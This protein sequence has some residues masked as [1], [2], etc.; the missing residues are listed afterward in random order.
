[1]VG[2]GNHGRARGDGGVARRRLR[3]H[4]A[5]GCGGGPDEDQPGVV[6][7]GR[8]IGILAEETVAGMDG[9]G[10]VAARGVEDAVD[11]QV[12]LRGGRGTQVRRFVGHADVE[13]G[14]VGVGVHRHGADAHLAQRAHHAHGDLAAIGDQDFAEHACLREL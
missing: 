12:A 6:A 14:A 9:F 3:T 2:P 8:E 5:D 1:M 4:R 11:A 10:A 13:R 7:G